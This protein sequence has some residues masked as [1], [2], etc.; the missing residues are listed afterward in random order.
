MKMLAISA[1]YEV[2]KSYGLDLFGFFNLI[3]SGYYLF[4]L[5]TGELQGYKNLG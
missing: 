1:V 3:K 4:K 5:E 2:Y